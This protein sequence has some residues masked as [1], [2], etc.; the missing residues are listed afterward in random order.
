MILLG[1]DEAVGTVSYH[2]TIVED[3]DVEFSWM[4]LVEIAALEF[5]P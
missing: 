5:Q 1:V 3:A 2:V 4:S